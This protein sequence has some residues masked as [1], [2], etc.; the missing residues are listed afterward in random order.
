MLETTIKEYRLSVE[1]NKSFFET[2]QEDMTKTAKKIGKIHREHIDGE[3]GDALEEIG[4]FSFINWLEDRVKEGVS[5]GV[6]EKVIAMY[7]YFDGTLSNK[8]THRSYSRAM[9]KAGKITDETYSHFQAGLYFTYSKNKYVFSEDINGKTN[10]YSQYYTPM[11]IIHECKKADSVLM[12]GYH[13]LCSNDKIFP[14]SVQN[15]LKRLQK[16]KAER[17][18]ISSL[19]NQFQYKIY[20]KTMPKK[21]TL[22]F[23]KEEL[24]R[25]TNNMPLRNNELLTKM[26]VINA[27]LETYDYEEIMSKETFRGIIK[28]QIMEN[29]SGAKK[30]TESEKKAVLT[31]NLTKAINYVVYNRMGF[32]LD[33]DIEKELTKA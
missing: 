14:T 6:S 26:F 17:T 28:N 15:A 7:V 18:E 23:V 10:Y 11:R 22:S 27:I 19:E 16:K 5:K 20:L 29:W 1:K 24:R 4:G 32:T 2:L 8:Y 12:D 13:Y 30:F 33:T 9:K 25:L 21:F 3:E 31:P